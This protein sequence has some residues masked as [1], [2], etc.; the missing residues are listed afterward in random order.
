V[1][2]LVGCGWRGLQA[3]RYHVTGGRSFGEEPGVVESIRCLSAH[4]SINQMNDDNYKSILIKNMKR[5]AD[6]K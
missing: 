1:K 2:A 6:F 4:R 5:Q 3:P